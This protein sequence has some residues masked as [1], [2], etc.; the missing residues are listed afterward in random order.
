MSDL[1]QKCTWLSGKEFENLVDGNWISQVRI[2]TVGSFTINI[3]QKHLKGTGLKKKKKLAYK[4][5]LELYIVK[6]SGPD[7]VVFT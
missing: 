1:S 3:V 6:S 2:L 4:K 7:I 5:D